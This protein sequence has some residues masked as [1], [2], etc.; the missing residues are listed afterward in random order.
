ML[1]AGE[2]AAKR[3]ASNDRVSAVTGRGAPQP[4]DVINNAGDGSIPL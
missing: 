1:R 3:I 4:S 2:S